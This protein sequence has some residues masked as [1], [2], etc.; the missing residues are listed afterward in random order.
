M[1][2]TSLT[3]FPSFLSAVS[4]V[5]DDR[6]Y[7][8]KELIRAEHPSPPIYD[9]ARDLFIGVWQG[10]FTYEAALRQARLEKGS[11]ERN[12]AVEVLE[13]SK[14]FLKSRNSKKI[15]KIQHPPYIRLPNGMPLKVGPLWVQDGKNR[16]AI[17]HFWLQALTELQVRAAAGILQLAMANDGHQYAGFE[18]DFI[19]TAM[20]H[21]ASGRRFSLLGWDEIKPLR[22]ADLGHFLQ[23]LYDLWDEYH[24]RR[25]QGR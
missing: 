13:I 9:L 14:R 7:G 23:K 1:F 22:D 5:T 25:A 8:I 16:L 6:E 10:D 17:L 21:Y 18:L 2:G 24:R 3:E 19:S 20:P 11:T 12:C 15:L 4:M